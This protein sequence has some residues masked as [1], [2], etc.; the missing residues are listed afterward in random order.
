MKLIALAITLF[1]LMSF[2]IHAESSDEQR[3]IETVSNQLLEKLYKTDFYN[4]LK[5]EGKIEV[6]HKKQN[7][8]NNKGPSQENSHQD[9]ENKEEAKVST[10][11]YALD[12]FKQKGEIHNSEYGVKT[13][14]KV[15]KF[16]RVSA[17]IDKKDLIGV[18]TKLDLMGD[19]YL[20]KFTVD[21]KINDQI[22]SKVSTSDGNDV[23]TGVF[24]NLGF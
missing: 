10:T 8:K 18:D 13:V 12:V 24:F 2:E 4:N 23:H 11:S 7:T 20:W 5:N 17:S 21:K 6:G 3:A 14:V 16:K 15:K 19:D 1:Y 22:S 9:K